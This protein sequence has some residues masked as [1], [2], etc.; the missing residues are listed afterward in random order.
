MKTPKTKIHTS[1]EHKVASV[2]NDEE[3]YAIKQ[4]AWIE[5][6]DFV[7]MAHQLE[8]LGN[9]HRMIIEAIALD[10]YGKR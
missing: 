5:N 7:I 4:K 3:L 10:I 1:L 2:K 6:G 8:K 9:M